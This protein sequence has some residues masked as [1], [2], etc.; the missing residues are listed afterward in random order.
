MKKIDHRAQRDH[1]SA[2]NSHQ[3]FAYF[4]YFTDSDQSFFDIIA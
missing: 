2:D 4:W 3:F 1:N